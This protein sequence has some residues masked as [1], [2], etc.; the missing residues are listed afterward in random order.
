MGIHCAE[1][2]QILQDYT[3]GRR[4][5][6]FFIEIGQRLGL[7]VHDIILCKGLFLLLDI[8]E[9]GAND[10]VIVCFCVQLALLLKSWC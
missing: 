6:P 10:L 2:N 4:V 3:D 5:L 7:P 1:E 8:D 9:Q